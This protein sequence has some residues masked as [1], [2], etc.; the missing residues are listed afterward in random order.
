MNPELKEHPGMASGMPEKPCVALIH[1]TAPPV[2]G[3]VEAVL[4]RQARALAAAG[5]PVR[6]I[7]GVAAVDAPGVEAVA[8]P[9]M[10]GAHS[11]IAPLQAALMEG[12]LPDAFPQWRERLRRA[13][14][15]ALH[16]VDVAILHN[17]CTMDKNLVLSAALY[18][19]V[20]EEPRRWI[21]WHHDAVI[22]RAGAP[23]FPGEPWELLVRPWPVVHVTVSEARR[24]ALAAAWGI[25][26]ALI[27]VIPNGVDFGEFFRWGAL[28]RS[29]VERLSLMAADAI[30]LTPVRITRRK[31]LEEALAVLRCL[32]AQTGWDARL[33]V[34]GPP[35]AHTPANRAYLEALRA[36]RAAW[37]LEGVAHFLY[38]HLGEGLPEEAV[39][40]FYTLADAVLLTSEEE[41]FGLPVLE[42]GLARL[43]VFAREL[44]PL[45]E[46]GREDVFLF[47]AEAAP[48]ALAAAIARFLETDPVARLRRRIRQ[49][50]DADR[51]IRE[52]L[53]PLLEETPS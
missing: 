50:F 47:P 46:L 2:V 21:G 6:I 9:P 37:G 10:Y 13:L 31:R 44:P 27:H 48:E 53:I 28:T 24:Q 18:D 43:P 51:L 12:R 36:Q 40:D 32:R 16:G 42:A 15:E 25:P 26:A 41:G 34:T 20:T 1:Y 5:Y 30:L 14:R 11:D 33:V 35:G 23:R 17:V 39:A 4:A 45:R 29:L 38:E 22:L 7:A 3:G 8:I 49:Q 19:L 52:R